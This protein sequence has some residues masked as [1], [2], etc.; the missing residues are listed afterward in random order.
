MCDEKL[1]KERGQQDQQDTDKRGGLV[2]TRFLA[3]AD[4]ESVEGRLAIGG[5]VPSTAEKQRQMLLLMYWNVDLKL[6]S[7]C[8]EMPDFPSNE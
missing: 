5:I 8:C 3:A 6:G 7:C 1:T 4:V 2:M